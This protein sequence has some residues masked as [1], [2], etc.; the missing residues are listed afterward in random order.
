[1]DPTA[2]SDTRK[3]YDVRRMNPWEVRRNLPHCTRTST[4]RSNARDIEP[5]ATKLLCVAVVDNCMT[6]GTPPTAAPKHEIRLRNQGLLVKTFPNAG[7]TWLSPTTPT[8]IV[9]SAWDSLGSC[10]W[11][12]STLIL[13]VVA[14]VALWIVDFHGLDLV[15]YEWF[16]Q[17]REINIYFPSSNRVRE[18]PGCMMHCMQRPPRS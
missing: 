14:Y 12:R 11:V 13:R 9:H 10:G 16:S 5:S 7:S 2:H 1:M 3:A 17:K 4:R 6:T 15:I 8:T 18:E